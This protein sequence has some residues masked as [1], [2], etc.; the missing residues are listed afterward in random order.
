MKK[1][2]GQIMDFNYGKN[3]MS[4]VQNASW[5]T[6]SKEKRTDMV[7]L[8]MNLKEELFVRREKYSQIKL[9]S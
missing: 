2:L 5:M 7:L 4:F 9:C 6:V 8:V 3:K 1:N